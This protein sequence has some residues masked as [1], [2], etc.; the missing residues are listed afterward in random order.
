MEIE[1]AIAAYLLQKN[2]NELTRLDAN[3]RATLFVYLIIQCFNACIV[4]IVNS[5]WLITI[6]TCLSVDLRGR[7]R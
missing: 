5:E 4:N 6:F 1:F 3:N 2:I 7:V